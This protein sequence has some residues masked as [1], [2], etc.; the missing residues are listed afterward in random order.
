[1]H[2]KPVKLDMGFDEA[3]RRISKVPRNAIKND[4]SRDEI[5][6]QVRIKEAVE[7]GGKTA[8]TKRKARLRTP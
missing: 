1:M 3:L 4:A 7:R 2:E 8:L 5:A 6:E